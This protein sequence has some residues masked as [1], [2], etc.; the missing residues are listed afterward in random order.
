MKLAISRTTTTMV[1]IGKPLESIVV[2]VV[3]VV[4]FQL[5]T[6]KKSFSFITLGTFFA[7]TGGVGVSRGTVRLDWLVG[8]CFL[9]YFLSGMATLLSNRAWLGWAN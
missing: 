5:A 8:Y 4:P 7:P 2:A 3:V 6:A 9:H 1:S